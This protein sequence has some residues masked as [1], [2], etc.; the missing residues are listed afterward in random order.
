MSVL[1]AHLHDKVFNKLQRYK[2]KLISTITEAK[3]VE[4][5]KKEV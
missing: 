3:M 1:S 5:M 4:E 2:E